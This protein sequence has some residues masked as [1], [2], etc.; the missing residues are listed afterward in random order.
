MVLLPDPDKFKRLKEASQ[1]V[2]PNK[3][4]FFEHSELDKMAK[5]FIGNN[6]R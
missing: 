3:T 5:Y 2:D 4:V 6:Q 1:N